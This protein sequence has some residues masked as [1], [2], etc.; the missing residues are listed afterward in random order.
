LCPARTCGLLY[1]LCVYIYTYVWIYFILLYFFVERGSHSVTQAKVQRRDHSSQQPQ[2]PGLK[3]S[4]CLS[5]PSSWNYRRMSLCPA[6]FLYF[7]RDR[8]SC[9]CSGWS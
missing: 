2:T 7:S 9:S 1:S 8:I 6:N 3:R 5:L 4:S